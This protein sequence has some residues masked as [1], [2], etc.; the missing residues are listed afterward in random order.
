MQT[1]KLN[2]GIEMHILGLGVFQFT[3]QKECEISV[4]N[5]IETG[6]RLID[7]AESYGNEEAVG[8][9]IKKKWCGKGRICFSQR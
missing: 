1:V 8:N 2:N 6:Y 7:I 4:I 9:A 5:A 3:D